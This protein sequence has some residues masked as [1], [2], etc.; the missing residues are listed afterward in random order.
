MRHLQDLSI[1]ELLSLHSNDEQS[2]ELA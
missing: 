2:G 1:S